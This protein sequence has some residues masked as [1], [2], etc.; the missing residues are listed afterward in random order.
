MGGY[1][2]AGDADVL[3]ALL[4]GIE[5]AVLFE[6]VLSETTFEPPQLLPARLKSLDSLFLRHLFLLLETNNGAEHLVHLLL[7]VLPAFLE[8]YIIANVIPA[9]LTS[10]GTLMSGYSP[11]FI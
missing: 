1:V 7:C 9:L 3:G 11:S 8:L 5:E 4:D 10:N 2:D 6:V